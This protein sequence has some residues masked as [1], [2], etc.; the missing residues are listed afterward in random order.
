MKAVVKDDDDLRLPTGKYRNDDDDDGGG[1][2][3]GDDDEGPV[4]IA[5]KEGHQ[6]AVVRCQQRPP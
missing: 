2:G 3:G 4:S 6:V 5:R 1:G